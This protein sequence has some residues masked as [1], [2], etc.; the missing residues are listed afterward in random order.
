MPIFIKID[1]VDGDV[2]AEGYEKWH[3][4]YS[5]SWGE[6]HSTGGGGGG[7][8]G[9]G[10]VAMQDMHITTRSGRGAPVL[11]HACAAGK[12]IPSVQIELVMQTNDQATA[13]QRWTLTNVQITSY[14][15]GGSGSEIPVD[16]LSMGFRTIKFE[17]AVQSPTGGTRF[18]SFTWDLAQGRG[19]VVP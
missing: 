16:S 4:V 2:T 7:G 11:A 10:K 5:Y 12:H 9:A 15:T 1:G 19:S 13:Y 14:Q 8:G 3:E 17:Q 18:Q 6:S